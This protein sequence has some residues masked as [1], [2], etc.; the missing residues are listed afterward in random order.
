LP[1]LEGKAAVESA[2]GWL[3]YE[4]G[5]GDWGNEVSDEN[6]LFEYFKHRLQDEDDALYEQNP[7]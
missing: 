3:E 2:R 7:N 4:K 5:Y 1:E 6:I